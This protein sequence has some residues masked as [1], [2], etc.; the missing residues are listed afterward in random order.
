MYAA[1]RD[2][3]AVLFGLAERCVTPVPLES[4]EVETSRTGSTPTGMRLDDM[5]RPY[6]ERCEDAKAAKTALP[7]PMVRWSSGELKCK[8]RMSRTG[9]RRTHRRTRG[10]R[11]HGA[12]AF[13]APFSF[14][15]LT[16]PR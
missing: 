15:S 5:L 2:C 4:V 11:I 10:R 12:P 3:E 6:I 8:S 13:F 16:V 9:S 1:A 7:K 14:A